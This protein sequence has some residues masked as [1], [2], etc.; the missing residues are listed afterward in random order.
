MH[1]AIT[2]VP[3][4]GAVENTFKNTQIYMIVLRFISAFFI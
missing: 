4:K 1:E 3:T 2:G